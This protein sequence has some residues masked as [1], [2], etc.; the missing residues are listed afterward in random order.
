MTIILLAISRKALP[1]LPISIAFG[2]TFYFVSSLTLV[3]FV[4]EL[5]F[6]GIMI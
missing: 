5:G 1:A 6:A 3:P 2:L 4:D